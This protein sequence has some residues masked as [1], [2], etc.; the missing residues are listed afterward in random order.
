M[1]LTFH[2]EIYIPL[3][4]AGRSLSSVKKRWGRAARPDAHAVRG[5]AFRVGERLRCCGVGWRYRSLGL[6]PS[7]RAVDC[8]KALSIAPHL[9]CTTTHPRAHGVPRRAG[10]DVLREVGQR[11]RGGRKRL[12]YDLRGGARRESGQGMAT[13]RGRATRRRTFCAS[14]KL[15]KRRIFCPSVSGIGPPVRRFLALCRG[16]PD[17][18]CRLRVRGDTRDRGWQWGVRSQSVRPAT[19]ESN[20]TGTSLIVIGLIGQRREKKFGI[21]QKSL[22]FKQHPVERNKLHVY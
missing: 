10:Q 19:C 4:N 20:A 2:G 1:M 3:R 12:A 17:K 16:P 6:P 21:Y 5:V 9:P 14:Q 18:R 13:H 7:V 22:A 11:L 15:V 8:A